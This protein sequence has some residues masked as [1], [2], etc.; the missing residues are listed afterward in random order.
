MIRWFVA[1]KCKMLPA[2]SCNYESVND[3]IVL[4][5]GIY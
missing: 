3:K 1:F 2:L 5:A 4:M